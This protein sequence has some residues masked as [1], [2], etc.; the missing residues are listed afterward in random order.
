MTAPVAIIMRSRNDMPL[1]RETLDAVARQKRSYELLVMD[2]GSTDGTSEEADRRAHRLITIPAG[3]YVPGKVLNHGMRE[4]RSPIVVFLNSDCTPQHDEWLERLEAAF[5]EPGIAAVFG[6]QIPRPECRPMFFKD[7]E[8]TFGD[9][10]RQRFWKHCFSMA[11]SA[12]RREV[13]ENHPFREDLQYSEDIDWTWR[14]RQQGYS[15]RYV[16]DSIVMHSHNYTVGQ[17]YRRQFGEGKAEAAIFSW[18]AWERFWLRYSLMPFVRQVL[19]DTKYAVKRGH[20]SLL[21]ES[22]VYR[23]AQM[24]GRR[25]GFLS[26][27]QGRLSTRQPS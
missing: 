9:G 3:T 15:I 4:T 19:A 20:P 12:I 13:W 7:T 22:P 10:A 5:T 18:S 16:P 25:A 8:E 23:F 26:G 27:L 11:S 14:M 6:R 17:W 2:N 1:I 24:L 21:L